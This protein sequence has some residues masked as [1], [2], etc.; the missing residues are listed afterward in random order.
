MIGP[1]GGDA[2][3]ALGAA[4][5]QEHHVGV[6]GA[7]FVERGP[8]AV[9]IVA[10]EPAGEG[11]AGAG[12]NAEIGIGALTRCDEIAAVDH[13]GGQ[14]PMV[15]DGTGAGT[16]SGPGRGL[17]EACGVIAEG[18]E[19]AA[20]QAGGAR[21]AGI[22]SGRGAGGASFARIPPSRLTRG[23]SG[24][25][26]RSI[27]SR[28]SSTRMAL[29]SSVK[30]GGTARTSHP[31]SMDQG[32]RHPPFPSCSTALR[33]S[34]C[35]SAWRIDV[36][37]SDTPLSRCRAARISAGRT[38]CGARA[39]SASS[40]NLAFDPRSRRFAVGLLSARARRACAVRGAGCGR[41]AGR[42]RRFGAVGVGKFLDGAGRDA[43]SWTACM[44]AAYPVA[45]AS[46][47]I[48]SI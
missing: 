30:S 4:A 18:F 10:V 15:E 8:D 3:G 32:I 38:A 34:N 37:A 2:L 17:E 48:S 23:D 19:D 31:Q 16:P 28:S 27:V 6:L 45:N 44:A 46:R 36:K 1:A 14:R 33:A 12:G 21:C 13:G 29:S 5:K 11:D 7:R 42:P 26:S 41:R 9:D 25:R 22:G 35:P 47:R 24:K 43:I 20:A 40:M 39:R